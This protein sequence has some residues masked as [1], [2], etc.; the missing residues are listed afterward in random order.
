PPPGARLTVAASRLANGT[1]AEAQRPERS[2]TSTRVSFRGVVTFVDPTPAAPAYTVSG[3]GASLLVHV[4]PDPTGAAPQ[5]PVRGSYVT[6]S[7]E[8]KKPASDPES[9]AAEPPSDAEAP[10][11]A[12]PGPEPTCARVSPQPAEATPPATLWQLQVKV[13]PGE[14]STYLDLAGV[15][16]AVCPEA[17]QLLLSAD[18]LDEDG[19]DIALAVPGEIA[20]TGL[21][22]GDSVLATATV[23]SDGSL[24]LAG[25]AS[26]ERIKGAD[27]SAAAQ[28]DLKR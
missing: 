18:G 3:R 19:S 2:G 12:V 6:V 8:L 25:L 4:E 11:A 10:T 27:D 7:A 28:G 13:E 14:P 23:E 5:L 1:F 26:D 9:L 20:T 16:T 22:L 21:A 17:G 24:A 15:L